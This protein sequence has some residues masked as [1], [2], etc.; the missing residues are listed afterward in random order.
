MH[1]TSACSHTHTHTHTHT[2]RTFWRASPDVFKNRSA[3][4]N[5]TLQPFSTMY[6]PRRAAT[7]LQPSHTHS[8][9]QLDTCRGGASM[10]TQRATPTANMDLWHRCTNIAYQRV[11]LITITGVQT[12]MSADFRFKGAITQQIN[13]RSDAVSTPASS[14]QSQSKAP[15]LAM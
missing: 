12:K 11:A 3:V 8:L 5:L 6:V 7:T 1:W 13:E 9:S 10:Q 14:T 15:L 4:V 2:L